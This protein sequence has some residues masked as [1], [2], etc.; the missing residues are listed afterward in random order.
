[1]VLTASPG[2][3]SGRFGSGFAQGHVGNYHLKLVF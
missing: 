3:G 1:M 2:V